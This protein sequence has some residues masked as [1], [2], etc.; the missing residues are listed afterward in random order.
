LETR[1]REAVRAW[2]QLER[3]Y[4]QAG[5]KFDHLAQREIG[6]R[7]EQFA[8]ELKRDPQ[9]DSVLRQRGQQ[10]GVAEGSRLARVVQSAVIDRELTRELGLRRSHSL[11]LGR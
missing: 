8:K 3:A 2:T 5:K 10:L 7:M 4:E 1:A 6:G 11:G 9:L